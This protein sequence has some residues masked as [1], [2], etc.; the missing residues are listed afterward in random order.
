MKN[1]IARY[2]SVDKGIQ[3]ISIGVRKKISVKKIAEDI[4]KLSV[5]TLLNLAN[6]TKKNW[7]EK[8]EIS[9]FFQVSDNLT[10]IKD[11]TNWKIIQIVGNLGLNRK[12]GFWEH[13]LVKFFARLAFPATNSKSLVCR[14]KGWQWYFEIM[15]RSMLDRLRNYNW[16]SQ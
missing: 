3:E 6:L 14:T 7:I 11:D 8:C 10:R 2:F 16:I 1:T 9:R 15:L 5:E 12:E 13:A 4:T